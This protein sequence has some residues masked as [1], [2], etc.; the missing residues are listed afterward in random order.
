[1][2]SNACTA[3]AAGTTNAAGDNPSG[4]DTACE[5]TICTE[6]QYVSSNVCT[7]CLEYSSELEGFT[8]PD[9]SI[10]AYGWNAAGG[11][12]SGADTTCQPDCH[13]GGVN[14]EISDSNLCGFAGGFRDSGCST[15]G[16]CRSCAE[17]HCPNEIGAY[18]YHLGGGGP[19]VC[20]GHPEID[21]LEDLDACACIHSGLFACMYAGAGAENCVQ[22][23]ELQQC[24]W[25]GMIYWPGSVPAW[26]PSPDHD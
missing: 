25:K 12:A 6:N 19:S 2:S 11:D 4:P 9:F 22:N 13:G 18:Q 16:S 5:A 14:G 24:S 17:L 21:S 15:S 23:S 10:S 7:W 20:S 8:H 3:C 1:V 26:P